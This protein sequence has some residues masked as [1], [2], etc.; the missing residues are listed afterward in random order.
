MKFMMNGAVTLGTMDGANVEIYER[1]GADNIFIFGA[2]EAKIA[3]MT[4]YHSYLPGE[5]YEKNLDIRKAVSHLIDGSLSS[6]SAHQFSELY[7]SLL[8]GG[9]GTPDPYYVLYDLPDY[10]RTFSKVC[11]RY[12]KDRSAWNRMA[13]I[14]TARSGYFS[15]DRTILEYNQK[16]W[17]LTSMADRR[18]RKE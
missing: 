17:H 15:S 2:N 7:Q 18:E 8:F 10:I 1:V 9:Y 13:A 16:I 11:D 4:A 3:R 6:A 5:L 12:R 14:N